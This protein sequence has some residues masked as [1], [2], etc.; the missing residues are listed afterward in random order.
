MLCAPWFWRP[1]TIIRPINAADN[2]HFCVLRDGHVQL[3]L[4]LTTNNQ[5]TRFC[6]CIYLL[7]DL[8]WIINKLR[9][10]MYV[11][12]KYFSMYCARVRSNSKCSLIS[13][14]TRNC[15]V[16]IVCRKQGVLWSFSFNSNTDSW[17]S[18]LVFIWFFDKSLILI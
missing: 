12:P 7:R 6:I 13:H 10:N 1:P 17:N 18:D 11:F 16:V 2:F 14:K 5:R 3:I 4:M 9:T 15:Q 8:T